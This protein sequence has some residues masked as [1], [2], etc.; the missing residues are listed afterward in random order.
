MSTHKHHIIPKYKCKELGINPNFSENIVEVSRKDHARIH[1]GYFCNDLRPLFEY[2]TPEQWIIDLIPIG[3]MKDMWAA[4]VNNKNEIAGISMSGESNPNWRHGIF[5]AN[6]DPEKKKAYWRTPERKAKNRAYE[7]SPEGKAKK[8]AYESSPK[9]KAK[10]KAYESSPEG[11]AKRWAYD[12]TPE[13]KAK[14]NTR[15]NKLRAKNLAETGFTKGYSTAGMK[16]ETSREGTLEG[17]M[18]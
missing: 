1:W 4:N 18:N 2:I 6:A 9:R 16:T 15:M 14:N 11:K 7:S 12:R 17:F 3:D 5:A 10:K 13:R 8:K